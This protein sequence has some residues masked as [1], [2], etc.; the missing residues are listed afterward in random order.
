MH[1]EDHRGEA[2]CATSRLMTGDVLCGAMKSRSHKQACVERLVRRQSA[3]Q[4][5]ESRASQQ[6]F[7]KFK[8]TVHVTDHWKSDED[9][10]YVSESGAKIIVEVQAKDDKADCVE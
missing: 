9:K 5:N 1:G 6:A 4:D 3:S 10:P 2:W 8:V 7:D